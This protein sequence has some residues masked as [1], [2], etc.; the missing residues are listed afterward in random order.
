LS[1]PGAREITCPICGQRHRPPLSRGWN[2]VPCSQD[3]GIVVFVDSG[4]NVREVHGASL[5]KASSG[6][7][8]EEGKLHLVPKWI[9]VDRIRAVIEGKAS[10]TEADRAGI[11]L[12]LNLG[13]L[14]RRT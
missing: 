11:S 5:S 7:V 6:L 3:H 10:P 1:A 13:I 14:K 4:G 8:L 12:L 2:F 9:N